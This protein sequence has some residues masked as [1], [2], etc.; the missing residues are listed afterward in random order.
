MA[1]F[2]LTCGVIHVS[3]QTPLHE[4]SREGHADIVNALIAAGACVN[5]TDEGM[6]SITFYVLLPFQETSLFT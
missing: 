4:A 3:G 5:T 2:N 6:L 1:C